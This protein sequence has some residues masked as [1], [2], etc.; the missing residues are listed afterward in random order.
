MVSSRQVCPTWWGHVGSS[1]TGAGQGEAVDM[2]GGRKPSNRIFPEEAESLLVKETLSATFP[3]PD[4]DYE[5]ASKMF[6]LSSEERGANKVDLDA[7]NPTT[8]SHGETAVTRP[9]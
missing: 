8:T 3:C 6:F 5:K 1:L 9:L 7:P 2:E 4:K